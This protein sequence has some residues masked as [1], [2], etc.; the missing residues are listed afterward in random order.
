[1]LHKYSP[2]DEEVSLAGPEKVGKA[3]V[4][5]LVMMHGYCMDGKGLA[6][7]NMTLSSLSLANMGIH[8]L[9]S[10]LMSHHCSSCESMAHSLHMVAKCYEATNY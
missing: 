9:A 8:S 5:A 3:W 7:T 10:L 1:M 2:M 6:T 4:A